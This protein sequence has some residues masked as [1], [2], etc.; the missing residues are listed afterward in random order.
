MRQGVDG[1][2]CGFAQQGFELGEELLDGIEI[3]TVGRQLEQSGAYP[4]DGQAHSLSLVGGEIVHDDDVAGRQGRGQ[5]LLDIGLEGS[6]VDGPVDDTGSS[7]IIAAESGEEGTGL[8]VTVRHGTDRALSA[9]RPAISPR[10]IGLDPGLIDEDQMSGVQR[11]LI[12]APGGPRRGNVW[13]ILFGGMER[14][15]LS[16]RPKASK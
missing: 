12:L 7:E 11:W 15:F 8:Q 16:V 5:N 3:G 13:A 14:L 1:S 6:R 2:G 10:H 9:Q 4:L